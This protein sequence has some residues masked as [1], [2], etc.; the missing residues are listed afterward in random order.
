MFSKNSFWLGLLFGCLFPALLFG[1]LFGLNHY[2]HLFDD[3][4][5][6]LSTQKMMFVAA[7]LNIIP[8]RYFFRNMGNH[9]TGAGML[10]ITVFLVFM[11][12][13]A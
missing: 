4:P 11:I 9:K 2:L 6:Q 12:F 1:F 8:I 13:L 10:A 3:P 7:A 5:V